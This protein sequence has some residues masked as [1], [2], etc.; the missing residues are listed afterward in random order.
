M[1][2]SWSCYFAFHCF[3]GLNK[4]LILVQSFT[5]PNERIFAFVGFFGSKLHFST[6]NQGASLCGCYK[7]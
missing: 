7:K 1:S 6:L 2:P 5:C 3:R 4:A